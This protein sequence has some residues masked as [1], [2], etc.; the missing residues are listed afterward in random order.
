MNR[1]SG[2]ARAYMF[3]AVRPG[4]ATDKSSSARNENIRRKI[5]MIAG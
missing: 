1:R 2:Q 5:H 3:A 4:S